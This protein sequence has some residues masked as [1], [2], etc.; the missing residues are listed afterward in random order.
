[1]PGMARTPSRR[2][3]LYSAAGL[4][5]AVLGW[6]FGARRHPANEGRPAWA[7][8]QLARPDGGEVRLDQWLGRPLL[9]HFWAT[10]CAPCVRELPALNAWAARQGAQGWQVLGIA[11]DTAQ[12]VQGFAPARGLHF[13]LALAGAQ[14]LALARELGNAQGG[15]PFSVALDAQGQVRWQK[16]GATEAEDLTALE[17]LLQQL[18]SG[19]DRS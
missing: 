17:T 1:M 3:F 4:G 11:A 5:A 8:V 14:G 18:T 13:P 6:T 12:A 2:T 10:W 15:L 9:L 7:G 16:R 19:K